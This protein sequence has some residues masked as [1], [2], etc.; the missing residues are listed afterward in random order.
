MVHLTVFRRVLFRSP[1]LSETRRGPDQSPE[2]GPRLRIRIPRGAARCGMRARCPPWICRAG[3]RY[4][5]PPHCQVS[6]HPTRL[7]SLLYSRWWFDIRGLHGDATRAVTCGRGKR[8][9][10]MRGRAVAVLA[11]RGA[12]ANTVTE[13]LNYAHSY[14]RNY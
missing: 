5:A 3:K 7:S 9:T 4:A 11:V 2:D 12:V 8:C 10:E 13:L 1:C 6:L 14:M